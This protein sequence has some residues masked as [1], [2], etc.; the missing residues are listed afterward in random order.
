[1]FIEIFFL[2]LCC[3]IYF[4]RI[5]IYLKNNLLSKFPLFLFFKKIEK[6]IK[7]IFNL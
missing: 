1:M 3:Y 6:I 7:D 5:L 4:K 2:I